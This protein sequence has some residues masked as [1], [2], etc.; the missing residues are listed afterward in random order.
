[1]TYNDVSQI[2][3]VLVILKKYM[4]RRK[5]SG[6]TVSFPRL[7]PSSCSKW[8]SRS[9]SSG[10]LEGRGC[11]FSLVSPGSTCGGE[12]RCGGRYDQAAEKEHVCNEANEHQEPRAEIT[13]RNMREGGLS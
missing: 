13:L 11:K 5:C 4:G 2:S 3:E 8:G 10:S 6:I 1:M 9:C 7:V 12:S